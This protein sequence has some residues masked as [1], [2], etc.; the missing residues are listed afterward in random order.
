MSNLLN[1]GMSKML[2]GRNGGGKKKSSQCGTLGAVAGRRPL[3]GPWGSRVSY[4]RGD[5]ESRRGQ[6]ESL[7]PPSH[8]RA[9]S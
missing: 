6:G 7:G 9:D 1:P 2:R 3:L 4:S 8:W 5:S